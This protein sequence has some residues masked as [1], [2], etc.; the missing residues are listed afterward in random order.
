MGKIVGGVTFPITWCQYVLVEV[1]P[2]LIKF[3]LRENVTKNYLRITA[4]PH[5]HLQALI[6]HLQRFKKIQVKVGGVAF[7]KYPVSKYV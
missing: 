4:N 3:K 7:T 6:K 5:T 1:E 2:K